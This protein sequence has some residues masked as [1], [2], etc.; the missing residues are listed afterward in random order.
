MFVEQEQTCRHLL[1]NDCFDDLNRMFRLLL[2]LPQLTGVS[3]MADAVAKLV[4]ELGLERVDQQIKLQ[5]PAPSGSGSSSSS[6]A[7]TAPAAGKKS[8]E[9][10]ASPDDPVYVKDIIALH[11]RFSDLITAQFQSHNTF[12]KALRDAFAVIMNRDVGKFK[13]ADLLSSYSDRLLRV[14][15]ASAA[16]GSSAGLSEAEIEVQLDKI[17]L[18]FSYTQDKD[19]FSEIYRNQLAKRLLNSKSASDEMERVMIGKL[20]LKCGTQFTSKMEGMLNDLS[21]GADHQ[22]Q[23][24]AHCSATGVLGKIEMQ[25]N[26]L[27]NGNWPTFKVFDSIFLPPIMLKCVKSFQEYYEEKTSHRRLSWQYAHGQVFLRACFG[28][29]KNVYEIQVTTLQAAVLLYF[30]SGLEKLMSMEDIQKMTNIPD[31]VLKRLLHSLACGK[32]RILKRSS[33]ADAAA[34]G[35]EKAN[36]GIKPTDLF[37]FNDSFT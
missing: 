6:S 11:D 22:A 7:A 5:N 17:V 37:A 20:K 16:S 34:A 25:V 3:R 15:G 23:F 1:I 12:Q 8:A 33:G 4:T 2:R 31:E 19:I 30:A 32:F 36:K 18:L 13:A 26:V 9:K 14:G 10:E 21:V 27:T 35:D 28:G 24:D 29:G